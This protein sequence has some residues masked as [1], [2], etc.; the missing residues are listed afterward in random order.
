VG[1]GHELK[2]SPKPSRTVKRSTV[3]TGEVLLPVTRMQ[4]ANLVEE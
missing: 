2:L 3:E 1:V 4:L